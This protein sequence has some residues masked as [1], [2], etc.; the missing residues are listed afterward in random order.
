MPGDSGGR[1]PGPCLSL[2]L[3][4]PQNPSKS[5]S[6][7]HP[8]SSPS[9]DHCSLVTFPRFHLPTLSLLADP[10]PWGVWSGLCLFSTPTVSLSVLRD[11]PPLSFSPDLRFALGPSE[12]PLEQPGK[13]L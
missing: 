5:L 13:I 6:P 10:S 2:P 1:W 9:V 11:N 3:S 12:S 8:G 4:P 7:S